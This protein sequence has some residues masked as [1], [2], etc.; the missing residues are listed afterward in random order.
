MK[1]KSFAGSAR[2]HERKGGNR[3]SG[4]E[5]SL[6]GLMSSYGKGLGD[7]IEMFDLTPL[8]RCDHLLVEIKD[9]GSPKIYRNSRFPYSAKKSRLDVGV[10][11]I[12]DSKYRSGK[13]FL[14]YKNALFDLCPELL[15]LDDAQGERL[16]GCRS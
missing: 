1:P 5:K 3:K 4:F 12:K 14:S 10:P 8:D 9:L 13:G 11:F 15:S 7:I 6:K 16:G 2:F